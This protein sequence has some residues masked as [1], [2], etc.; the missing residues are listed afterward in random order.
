MD[1]QYMVCIKGKYKVTA[2]FMK[3]MTGLE[4]GLVMLPSG[5]VVAEHPLPAIASTTDWPALYTRFILE[6]EVPQRCEGKDGSYDL[7][8]YSEPAM[9][10]FRKMVER[11]GVKYPVLVKSTL[12]YYKTHKSYA[13]TISRYIVDGLWRS[14]Y[15]ALLASAADG[16]IEEHIKQEIDGNTEFNRYRRG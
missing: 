9:K 3:E 2:K 11:E 4:T 10:A 1:N 12:L 14:D 7:N 5:P 8:K 6:A 13:V 16:R 15:Q